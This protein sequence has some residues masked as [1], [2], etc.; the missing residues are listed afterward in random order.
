MQAH[1]FPLLRTLAV[2]AVLV[3]SI[4]AAPRPVHAVPVMDAE[5]DTHWFTNLTAKLADYYSQA[6]YFRD[7]LVD[8]GREMMRQTNRVMSVRRRMEN[9]A[10]GELGELG[11]YVPDWRE[12]ANFCAVDVN[13]YDVCSADAVVMRRFERVI[14]DVLYDFHDE[15]VGRARGFR[16]QVDD[17]VGRQFAVLGDELASTFAAPGERHY[18]QMGNYLPA[19]AEATSRLDEA[20]LML[21]SLVDSAQ[22]N[23]VEGQE[24]SSGRAR[25]L[26]AHLT[27][28]ETVVEFELARERV[29]ALEATTVD[30]ANQIR[31]TR[32]REYTEVSG[33]SRF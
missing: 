27:Y 16:E 28:A 25:Q 18:A 22:V 33:Y 15:V 4:L 3:A 23:E 21:A 9:A 31:A 1:P 8:R 7:E 2:S 6:V 13:G 17:V 20:A 14:D 12:Y 32:L 5:T 26:V 24:M 11:G 30:A 10:V 29:G 19:R